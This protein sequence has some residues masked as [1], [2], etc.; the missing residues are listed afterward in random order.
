[1]ALTVLPLDLGRNL[2]RPP[3]KSQSLTRLGPQAVLA[4]PVRELRPPPELGHE[5][6][7]AAS[8][9]I[10]RHCRPVGG[11][12]LDI[13]YIVVSGGNPLIWRNL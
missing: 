5:P 12:A 11:K 10:L 2:C 1:V 13:L 6:L 7:A 9:G 8:P 4:L 3:Q